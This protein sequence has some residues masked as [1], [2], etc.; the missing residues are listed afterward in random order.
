M[1]DQ[2]DQYRQD[3]SSHQDYDDYDDDFRD[4]EEEY[5]KGSDK[6]K[7]EIDF[8]EERTAETTEG[9]EFQRSKEVQTKENEIPVK[10][11]HRVSQIS[12]SGRLILNEDQITG[13]CNTPHRSVAWLTKEDEF[14]C[15]SCQFM[16]C[17][18]CIRTFHDFDGKELILCVHCLDDATRVMNKEKWLK[19][20]RNFLVTLFD[21]ILGGT[22][23]LSSNIGYARP[24]LKRAIKSSSSGYEESNVIKRVL[25]KPQKKKGGRM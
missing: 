12:A 9:D 24:N 23:A 18:K 15:V 17:S 25:Q 1:E 6:P 2:R 21:S 16:Y 10:K 20:A 19:V 4:L 22:K 14:Q 11:V 3:N 5:G 13:R 7:T 8:Q